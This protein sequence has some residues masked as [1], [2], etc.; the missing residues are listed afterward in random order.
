LTTL[1][2]MKTSLCVTGKTHGTLHSQ[3]TTHEQ[4]SQSQRILYD[5]LRHLGHRPALWGLQVE[6]QG[7]EG[8]GLVVV[9]EA[10]VQGRLVVQEAE[11]Q[12]LQG[13][14]S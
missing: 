10:E 14:Q 11:G 3:Q 4:G 9:Q 1:S 8:Q 13:L 12:G 5:L 2:H 6:G 7:L